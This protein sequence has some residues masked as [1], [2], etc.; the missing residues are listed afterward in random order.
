MRDNKN[1]AP[2]TEYIEQWK[3]CIDVIKSNNGKRNASN[4]AFIGLAISSFYI[5][6]ANDFVISWIYIVA[7]V[8]CSAGWI[9]TIY[10]YK[11]ANNELY[12]AIN[13][14][15]ERW[16]IKI[17]SNRNKKSRI[18]LSYEYI[19]PILLSCVSVLLYFYR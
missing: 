8:A 19:F 7:I 1:T 13:R 18:L 15:E 11:K 2:H 12:E 6:Y 5:M 14:I 17:F 16:N 3:T 4:I 10:S 9:L